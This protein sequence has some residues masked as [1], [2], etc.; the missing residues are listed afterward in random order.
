MATCRK[1]TLKELIATREREAGTKL[2][3]ADKIGLELLP[4]QYVCTG[5]GVGALRGT[6]VVSRRS[7][8]GQRGRARS[9]Y[10]G[11]RKTT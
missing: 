2:S 7:S 10:A 4:A 1:Q 5:D 11:R 9:A 3:R 8:K 6:K